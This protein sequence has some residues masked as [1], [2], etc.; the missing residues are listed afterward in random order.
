MSAILGIFGG[1][2]PS[3][4]AVSAML[5]A[6]RRRGAEA[7]DVWRT[8]DAVMAV[9]RH[10]WELAPEF[11]GRALVAHD[12]PLAVAADA[13]LYYRRDLLT[14]LDAAGVVPRG[15]T[16]SHLILAAYRAWGDDCV[17]HLEGDYAFILW[18]GAN[19]RALA[20]RDFGGKRP[21]HF[22]EV[23]GALVVGSTIGGVAAHPDC[24]TDLNVPLLAG[25]CAG[26]HFSAGP[27]T[28]YH[29]IRVLPSA[30]A[31]TRE[32]GR[33]H[34]PRRFWE[35]PVGTRSDVP[36]D[37]AAEQLR[38]LLRTAT[39]ERMPQSGPTSVW[40]SGGW[41]STSVFAA[42][43]DAV[44]QGDANGPVL[45]VSISYPEGDPGREDHWI[46]DVAGHWNAPIH[47][48]DIGEIPFLDREADRA[49]ERDEPYAHLYARWNAALAGGSRATGARVAFDGNGGDQL[50]QNS[51]IFMADLFRSG[52]WLRLRREWQARPRGG[53]RHFF[54]M[55]VQPNMTPAMHRAATLLRGGRRLR[56]YLER[57]LPDWIR[58]EFIEGHELE[59]RDFGHLGRPIRASHAER[60]IDWQYTNSFIDRAF[61]LIT[62][63]ALE[64]GVEVRSPLSDRRIVELALSRPWWE[65]SSGRETKLLLR[66]AMKGL[67]PENVL[68]PRTK[69][70]GVTAGYSHR[71]MSEVF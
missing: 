20:A 34:G 59:R 5:G 51:D 17:D 31:L 32:S 35:P 42:A 69:R 37:Q 56:H 63:W 33:V 39:A 44:R 24:P 41:D 14:A 66:A 70:T 48:L 10:D 46:R 71:W 64:Q 68:A 38:E 67:M 15:P 55:A 27:E 57:P 2:P 62:S 29:A 19:R 40:M 13:S 22:A 9:A 30:Q 43:G 25:T 28:A 21:L 3:E 26:L 49:A 45:P 7:V 4:G 65:R 50:F 61:A 6:M 60:E 53:F 1:P 36:F 58:P 54:G 8:G 18:D 47:W 11:S 12:G 52:R 16:P 23:G